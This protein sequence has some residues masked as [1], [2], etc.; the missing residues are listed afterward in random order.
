MNVYDLDFFVTVQILE[1]T[2]ASPTLLPQ[3]TTHDSSSNPATVRRRSTSILALGNQVRTPYRY[4]ETCCEISQRGHSQDFK[5]NIDR[6]T[7]IKGHTRRHFSRFRSGTSH[8]SGIEEAQYFY[9][10]PDR[11]KLLCAQEK[12]DDKGSLQ[13]THW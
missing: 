4:R 2:P 10:L 3:D 9:S 11:S 5:E 13:K 8:Q 1:D 6:S 12:Q 7:S